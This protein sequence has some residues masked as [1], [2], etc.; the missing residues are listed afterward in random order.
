MDSAEDAAEYAAIDNS[1]VN[2]QFVD[3]VLRLA[4]RARAP[5]TS[6]SRSR[7]ARSVSPSPPSTWGS[8]CS[9]TRAVTSRAPGSG[10]A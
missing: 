4:P 8:T 1:F 5:A 2:Q 3:E 6:R 7:G 10:T 9:S